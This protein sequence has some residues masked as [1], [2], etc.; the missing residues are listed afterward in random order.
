[1]TVHDEHHPVAKGAAERLRQ[2]APSSEPA[3]NAEQRPEAAAGGEARF[4]TFLR[5]T[6]CG[7]AELDAGGNIREVNQRASVILGC[8]AGEAIGSPFADFVHEADREMVRA[9]FQRVLQDAEEPPRECRIGVLGKGFQTVSL[10][11]GLLNAGAAH[12]RVVY[13]M[14]VTDIRDPETA[15][16]ASETQ[17]RS[18]LDHVPDIVLVVSPEDRI[19]HINRTFG[20]LRS[21]QLTGTKLIEHFAPEDHQTARRSLETVRSTGQ[22]QHFEVQGV[23][24]RWLMCRAVALQD[25]EL[26]IASC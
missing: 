11:A 7:Y 9:G 1:M 17:L 18:L 21:S 15:L 25:G 24:G 10:I 20:G 23:D 16:R 22:P 26:R 12:P 4:L 2:T 14:D 5:S 3:A 13:L 19:E 6:R 8:P